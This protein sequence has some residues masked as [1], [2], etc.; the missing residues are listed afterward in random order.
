MSISD[1][2]T[3]QSGEIISLFLKIFLFFFLIFACPI[4]VTGG[5]PLL[6]SVRSIFNP[7]ESG[8]IIVGAI[9]F[10]LIVTTEVLFGIA[11]LSGLISLAIVF[12][13]IS[14]VRRMPAGKFKG[15][16]GVYHIRE[17]E[18]K[19][20]YDETFDLCL[21]AVLIRSGHVQQ[22]DQEKGRIEAKTIIKQ[23]WGELIT[24]NIKRID[25]KLTTVEVSSQPL[26]RML[27]DRGINLENVETIVAFLKLKDRQK[28]AAHD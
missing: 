6:N 17:V 25:D 8:L 28:R 9:L 21:E 27:T 4:A 18:L 20:P 16:L 23:S 12:S 13:H 2:N 1:P 19:L 14:S 26:R 24:F 5:I 10:I 11:L 22:Q 3:D 15:A 7:Q